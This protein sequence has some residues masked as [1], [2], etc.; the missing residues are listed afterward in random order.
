MDLT[1]FNKEVMQMCYIQVH[2]KYATNNVNQFDSILLWVLTFC[3]FFCSH[4]VKNTIDV[5]CEQLTWF[6][7]G[8]ETFF[9]FSTQRG[10]GLKKHIVNEPATY[11]LETFPIT[12]G[13]R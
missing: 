12:P 11:P 5:Y 1:T 7:E 2:K 10:R 6:N 8:L 4:T 9:Y 3:F 13:P